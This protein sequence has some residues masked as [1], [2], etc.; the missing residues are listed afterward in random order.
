MSENLRGYLAAL[1]G[2]DAVVRRMPD[3]GWDQPSKCAEWTCRDVVGHVIGTAE[4]LA[5]TVD[6][7]A[8][9]ASDDPVASWPTVRNTVVRALDT[10]GALAVAVET[11]F[12]EMSVDDVLRIG[13]SDLYT[14]TWDIGAAAGVDPALDPGLA[15]WLLPGLIEAGDALRGPEMLGPEVAVAADAGPVDRYLGV[16]GRH[17]S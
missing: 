1:Y 17:P 16:S 4:W 12:G 8:A 2:F 14:H 13:A 15:E 6:A 11:P 5:S 9:D 7:D 10:Q 3:D